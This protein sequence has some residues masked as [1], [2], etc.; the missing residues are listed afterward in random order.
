MGWLGAATLKTAWV[1]IL[2]L[3]HISCVTLGKWLRFSAHVSSPVTWRE[4]SVSRIKR[5]CL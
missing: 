5:V 1:Q 4:Y 2:S 3:T